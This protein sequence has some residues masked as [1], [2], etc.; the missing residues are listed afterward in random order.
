[1]S[2]QPKR[3][4]VAATTGASAGIGVATARALAADGNRVALLARRVDGIEVLADE[5]EA[6]ETEGAIS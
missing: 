1:M 2:N 5:L 3:D 6:N 4:R